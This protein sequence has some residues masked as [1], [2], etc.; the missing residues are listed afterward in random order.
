MTVLGAIVGL[1]PTRTMDALQPEFADSGAVGRQ[2]VGRNRLGMDALVAQQP[3][4]Q[5]QRRSLVPPLLDQD[6]ENFA[7]VI[8]GALEP[9]F[10]TADPDEHFVQMPAARRWV[11]ATAEVRRDQRTE[12][13]YP[14]TDRLAT[15]FDAALGEQF[16]DIP[17]AEREPEIQPYGLADHI[18]REPVAFERDRL[19]ED[20]HFG[21]QTRQTGD[22]LQLDC[23]HRQWV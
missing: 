7:L 18:R 17:D 13:D 1:H 2:L 8:D 9:H 16:L 10:S 14:A 15:D 12:L 20:P 23:Q 19:H 22:I 6:I 11:P 4:Q 5:L 3:T 21:T